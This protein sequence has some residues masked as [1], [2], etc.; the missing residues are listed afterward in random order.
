MTTHTLNPISNTETF[1]ALNQIDQDTSI[2]EVIV[3]EENRK[4]MYFQGLSNN[5]VGWVIIQQADSDERQLFHLYQGET[6]SEPGIFTDKQL[7][8]QQEQRG[9][10]DLLAE[11]DFH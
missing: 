4:Q 10:R 2:S 9:I 11:L 8:G 6:D 5:L 7:T 3:N 1:I